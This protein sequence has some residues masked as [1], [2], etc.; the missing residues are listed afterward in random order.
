MRVMLRFRPLFV[1]LLVSIKNFLFLG[2]CV[3]GG[4]LEL[5]LRFLPRFPLSHA[6][7]LSTIIQLVLGH[8]LLFGLLY[9][10]SSTSPILIGLLYD[11]SNKQ[12][13]TQAFLLIAK[14]RCTHTSLYREIHFLYREIHFE[15]SIRRVYSVSIL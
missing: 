2:L 3:P 9:S 15:T 11:T 13:L 12:L 1:S 6:L 7:F 14:L 5:F 4:A 10:Y 8:G